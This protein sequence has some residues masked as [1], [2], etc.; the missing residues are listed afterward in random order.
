MF[1]ALCAITWPCDYVFIHDGARPLITGGDI[2]ALYEAVR[3]FG[4]VVAGSPC[5]DTVK[6]VD[7]EQFV[8][9]D[10]DRARLW[11]VQTPQVFSFLLA[12]R[13]YEALEAQRERIQMEHI[14][15]TDDAY[16]AEHFG[17]ARVKLIDTGNA[18]IK[19][20]TPADLTVAE[21]L[22]KE[23]ESARRTGSSAGTG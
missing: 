17:G 2:A 23:R 7:D 19:V 18:N 4:A 5:R 10:P 15:V 9:D 3:A 11:N 13:S 1:N 16:V 20:T 8:T 14:P 22:L 12:K 6:V 21:A